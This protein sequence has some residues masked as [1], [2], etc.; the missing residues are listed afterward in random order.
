[1]RVNRDLEKVAIELLRKY[2]IKPKKKLG[3]NFLVSSKIIKKIVDFAN[4]SRNDVVLEIGGG[5][6]FL[7]KVL[8]ERAKKVIVIEIDRKLIEAM[9][10]YL[11]DAHNVEVIHADVLKVKLPKVDKIVSN[12]PY[13]ISSEITFK[14]LEEA[15]FN[16]A[17][18]T[19]QK[20][21]V[22]RMIAKPNTEDYGRLTVMVN[23]YAY[24]EPLLYIPRY[25]FY[26]IPDV[27][28]MTVKLIKRKLDFSEEFKQ[29]FSDV[30][31]EMFT[32]RNKLWRKVLR[33]YL[34]RKGYSRN[35]ADNIVNSTELHHI[36]AERVR[37]LTLQDF[38]TITQ[39]L[40]SRLNHL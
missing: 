10:E 2:K 35:L 25:Y 17:I 28:S 5:L 12:L 6:G 26:P 11:E 40:L 38:I 1:M 31:K 19:Y 30:V 8:A 20:E 13:S 7:T 27:D 29:L 9:K 24:V 21:V 39:F 32:Q 37:E 34:I 15:E 18:L 23:F 4:L 36:K 3:Q 14:L 22:N 16:L 33:T